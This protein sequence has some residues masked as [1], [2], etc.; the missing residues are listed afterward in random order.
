MSKLTSRQ[1]GALNRQQLEDYFAQYP[2]WISAT[3]LARTIGQHVNTVHAHYRNLINCGYLEEKLI[4]VTYSNNRY[5]REVIHYQL[6]RA[7]SFS[8]R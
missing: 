1:I 5:G 6:R 2:D 3:N 8:H 7:S 4:R